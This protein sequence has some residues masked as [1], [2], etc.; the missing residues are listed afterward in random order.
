MGR[1]ETTLKSELVDE[2]GGGMWELSE[3]LVYYSTLYDTT[4]TVPTGFRTDFASVPRLPL[5]YLLAGDT[6][7]RPATVHDYLCRTD[8]PRDRADRIFLEAMESIGVPWWRRNL[9]Y[10]AVRA[11]SV[12]FGRRK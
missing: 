1:F 8:Y 4:V 7:H 12:T 11:Y 2:S 3:P 6:A 10:A 5:A 9:M